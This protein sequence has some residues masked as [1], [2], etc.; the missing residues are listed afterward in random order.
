MGLDEVVAKSFR[1]PS[2]ALKLHVKHG[3]APLFLH[4]CGHSSDSVGGRV[5]R[6]SITDYFLSVVAGVASQPQTLGLKKI[7]KML[8]IVN[9]MAHHMMLTGPH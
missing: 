8:K 6:V 9:R 2:D 3:A 4:Y 1:I 5:G 7:Q